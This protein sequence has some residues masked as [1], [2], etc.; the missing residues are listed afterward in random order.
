MNNPQLEELAALHAIGLLDAAG[1]KLLLDAAEHDS[2]VEQMVRDF[3]ESAALMAYDAPPVAPPP[4]LQGELMRRLPAHRSSS[5]I[6]A[7]PPWIPY[8]LA[9]CLMGLIVYQTSRIVHQE[10]R[11]VVLKE[12]VQ[13]LTAREV[14][15]T[16][17]NDLANLRLASLEA[18]D[19]A[20]SSAKVMV[21]WDPKMHHGMISMQDMPAPPAGHSYQLWVLDPSEQAPLDA[22]VLHA[23]SGSESFA[24]HPISTNGP[25]FAISL[26]P[27]GGRP[28]PTGA[29]LFAVAP[30][31]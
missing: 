30:G 17:Q 29:I 2:E 27:A 15:L 11:I 1:M 10:N 12:Q 24:V 9:A 31:R 13:N 21:A 14:A 6:I 3:A 5:K 4:A 8:A 28:A 18:K 7:F 20:Y 23:V 16:Q 25:G 26:E 19:A 22:G